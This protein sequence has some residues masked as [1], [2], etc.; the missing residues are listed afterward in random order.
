MKVQWISNL[1]KVMVQANGC[2]IERFLNIAVNRNLTISEVCQKTDGSISFWTTPTTF[3]QMK[4]AAKKTGVR[5]RVLS[6]EG[7]P[8][9]LH[10]NRTRKLLLFGFLSFFL[11]LYIMSFYIWDISFEGNKRFTDEILLHYMETLPVVHGMRKSLISC[12]ELEREI[13]NHFSEITWI[14]AEISGTRL[15]IHVKEN[16]ALTEKLVLD[17]EPCDLMARSDGIITRLV[18][19]NGIGYVKAGMEVKEGDLLV[20]GTVPIFD[21]FGNLIRNHELHADAEVYAQTEHVL[22]KEIPF[23][24]TIT[25]RTG[26]VR[27]GFYLGLFGRTCYLMMPTDPDTCWEYETDQ[28]QV[29]LLENFYLPVYVGRITAYEYVPYDDVYTKEK[30]EALF[31][32][33]LKEYMEKLTEKGIQILG[34]D[35]KIEQSESGW[36]IQGILTVIENI[37]IEAV[38]ES[39]E[40]NESE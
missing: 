10:K 14:S 11:L 37:A 24:R 27:K 23:A 38:P 2:Q 22:E 39:I 40:P 8:F 1:G 13:R 7:L 4:P 29:K 26:S 30:A 35:G 32:R 6:R 17:T 9:V 16:E 15:T 19:R 12:D 20:D 28:K 34:Y 25:G 33:Y 21:D 18:L 31:E 36:Q 5:L 3:K